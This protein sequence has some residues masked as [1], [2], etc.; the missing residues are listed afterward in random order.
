LHN[1]PRGRACWGCREASRN[2]A[3]AAIR[4]GNA[5]LSINPRVLIVVQGVEIQANGERTW[6]GGGLADVGSRTLRLTVAHRVVYSTHEYPKSVYPQPWFNA[7]NY[8]NNLKDHWDRTWGYLQRRKIAPVFIG[9]FGTRLETKS[10]RQWLET[11]V[12]YVRSNKMSFG[13]WSYNPN[14]I[15][16]GGLLKDDWESLQQAKLAKLSPILAAT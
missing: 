7:R 6:W 1:E 14:N 10:D 13:Y 8:P 3:A 11:L 4:A 15:D 12:P 16:T 9:E 2:W 5:I